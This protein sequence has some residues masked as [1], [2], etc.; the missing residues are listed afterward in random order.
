MIE[1]ASWSGLWKG[2]TESRGREEGQRGRHEE[3][4]PIFFFKGLGDRFLRRS[5]TGKLEGSIDRSIERARG[6]Q[7][8][9][10]LRFPQRTSRSPFNLCVECRRSP[11]ADLPPNPYPPKGPVLDLIPIDFTE[12]SGE[13]RRLPPAPADALVSLFHPFFVFLPVLGSV[14]AVGGRRRRGKEGGFASSWDS[15]LGFDRKEGRGP[16]VLRMK[17]THVPVITENDE[18]VVIA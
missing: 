3:Q 1:E 6:R 11:E 18:M 14:A 7:K 10:G 12:K 2:K 16:R 17:T 15:D 5:K 9:S 13:I 8:H 4:P